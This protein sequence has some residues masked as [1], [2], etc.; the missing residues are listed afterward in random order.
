[1]RI[2]RSL[3]LRVAHSLASFGREY[4][5]TAALFAFAAVSTTSDLAYGQISL[6]RR[7][8]QVDLPAP[9]VRKSNHLAQVPDTT[10][11][12]LPNQAYSS[13]TD[14]P[15]V[16]GPPVVSAQPMMYMPYDSHMNGYEIPC[17]DAGCDVSFYTSFEA[18]WFKREGDERLSLS[19]NDRFGEFEYELQG[20]YTAGRLFD[21]V[22]GIEGV[23]VGPY[24]WRRQTIVTGSGDLISRFIPS[25]GY[26]PSEVNAFNSADVH[27]QLHEVSLSSYE[28][29]RRWWAWDV[30]STMIGLRA[31]DYREHYAFVSSRSG[32]GTGVFTEDTDNLMVG[33]QVGAD[34]MYPMGL[35]T[36]VGMRGKAGVFA[37]FDESRVLLQNA[38]VLVLDATD[39]DIDVAGLV[40]YGIYGRYQVVPSIR[41]TAGYEFW[42][43]PGM[44]TVSA[45][46][47]NRVHPDSGNQ[48][49]AE[50]DI[51]L[52]GGSVG[53]QILF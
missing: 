32:V 43:L 25:N 23:F 44:A 7:A 41:L 1:M 47:I 51:F 24:D 33:V 18:L 19:R 10:V 8:E 15:G 52:H 3:F 14:V 11:P 40:E 12:P 45:Q 5:H 17:P 42:Y 16:I 6:G 28:I 49:E 53:V 31:V 46:A 36:T 38:G 26:T 20:R 37:N 21:C 34:M 22:N 4:A 2:M 9:A 35:R 39:R 50:D 30:L 29:N 27:S 48:V 13:V